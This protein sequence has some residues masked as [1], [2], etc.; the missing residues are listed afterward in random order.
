[1]RESQSYKEV[2]DF[3]SATVTLQF[4]SHSGDEGSQA[5][6]Q[7]LVHLC[8]RRW[9]SEEQGEYQGQRRLHVA[10]VHGTTGIHNQSQRVQSP[11]LIQNKWRISELVMCNAEIMMFLN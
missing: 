11:C 4:W 5:A 2:C 3:L 8:V 7:T 10:S 1:M 6:A 9:H